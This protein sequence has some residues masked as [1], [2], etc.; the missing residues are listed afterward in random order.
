[1]MGMSG[2]GWEDA[3]TIGMNEKMDK[4]TNCWGWEASGMTGMG[5]ERGETATVVELIG[6]TGQASRMMGR[7]VV[8]LQECWERVEGDGRL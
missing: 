1:M 5:R 4:W 2:G 6:R 3:R 8:R 7:G